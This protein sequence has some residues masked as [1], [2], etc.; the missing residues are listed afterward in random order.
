MERNAG[1]AQAA[2]RRRAAT[3]GDAGV[4][5]SGGPSVIVSATSWRPA[6]W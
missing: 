1:A 2:A 5:C 3:L 6:G 4:S